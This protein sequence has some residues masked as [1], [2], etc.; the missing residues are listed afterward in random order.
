MQDWGGLR[1]CQSDVE[2]DTAREGVVKIRYRRR[3]FGSEGG[4]TL[5][6]LVVVIVVIGIVSGI[7]IY[8]LSS[9]P[10][11]ARKLRAAARKALSD[12]RYAQD[13]AIS[14]G[15]TV[16]IQ[17][18]VQNNRYLLK[19]QDET[20]VPNIMGSG[21]FVVDYDKRDF[22][23]VFISGTDISGGV[24]E[25]NVL[26]VPKIS[27]QDLQNEMNV[28]ELNNRLAIRISPYTGHM[29]LIRLGQPEND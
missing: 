14:S 21:H 23:G 29:E 8:R 15:K 27:G 2:A 6:E 5:F 19:W 26:G 9:D 12:F 1:G 4:W 7:A 13:L 22:K 17:I 24:L 11:L 3:G 18:D 10:P 28:L 25:F 16:K 20:H